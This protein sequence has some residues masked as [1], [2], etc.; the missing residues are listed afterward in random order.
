MP[1]PQEQLPWRGGLSMRGST[2]STPYNPATGGN[3][4]F[5]EFN[6]GVA[7]WDDQS[8]ASQT[9]RELLKEAASIS[10]PRATFVLYM[11]AAYVL[12]LVPLNWLICRWLGRVEMAWAVAP[13]IAVVFGALSSAWRSWILASIARQLKSRCWKCKATI[14]GPS[15]AVLAAVHIS[16]DG[17]HGRACQPIGGC[18]A[19]PYRHRRGPATGRD[20]RHFAAGTRDKLDRSSCD[21]VDESD[22]FVQFHR[23]GAQRRDACPAWGTATD[24]AGEARGV[25]HSE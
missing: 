15:D 16:L 18:P 9:A 22:G 23:N 24:A 3:I 19:I 21:T 17:L 14:R 2:S 6:A 8:L 13:L 4:H 7:S 5:N 11:L 20:D 25:P 1:P 12:V 10:V